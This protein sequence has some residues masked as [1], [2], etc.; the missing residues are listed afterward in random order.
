MIVVNRTLLSRSSNLE[1]VDLSVSVISEHPS[2]VVI[3]MSSSVFGLV[4]VSQNS[5][6]S[7]ERIPVAVSSLDCGLTG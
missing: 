6:G 3:E 1:D 2:F 4:G 5:Q 7:V